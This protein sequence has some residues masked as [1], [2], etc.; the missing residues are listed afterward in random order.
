MHGIELLL[1]N[2]DKLTRLKDMTY[3]DGV[4][5]EELENLKT[6]I[7]ESNLNIIFE[8]TKDEAN[9]NIFIDD[10]FMNTK[11]K[12]KYPPCTGWSNETTAGPPAALNR[13]F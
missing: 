10:N 8:D 2:C 7:K 9:K 1:A 5:S 3:F 11:M 13:V 12:E 4:T 6:R